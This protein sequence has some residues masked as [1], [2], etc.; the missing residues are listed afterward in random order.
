LRQA[1]TAI[2][3]GDKALGKQLLV[4]VLEQDSR[5]EHAW[6][7]L[8]QCVTSYEQKL[9]CIKRVLDINPNDTTAQKE[10]A[11]LQALSQIKVQ[12]VLA[13]PPQKKAKSSNLLPYILVTAV[14]FGCICIFAIASLSGGGGGDTSGGG[15]MAYYMCQDFIEKRLIAPATAEW[16]SR[17]DITVL[18]IRGKEEAYQVRGYVDSQNGFG[19]LIRTNYVCEV[20]YVGNGQWHLDYLNFDE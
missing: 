20:S 18:P 16:P 12:P 3:S 1:I 7:W 17:S 14:V 19:A 8:S 11:R 9:D 6:L 15:T 13:K 4:Q 5:N 2:K 10:L